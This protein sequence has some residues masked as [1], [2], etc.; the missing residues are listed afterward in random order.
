MVIVKPATLICWLRKAVRLFWRWKSPPRRR[1]IPLRLRQLIVQMVHDN[2]I[3][4]EE[5]IADELWPKLGIHVSPRTVRAY[6][7]AQNP[8]SG[9]RSPSWNAFV[10]NHASALVACNFLIAVTVH[11]RVVYVFVVMEITSTATS[12]MIDMRRSQANWTQPSIPLDC[13]R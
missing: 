10:R 7:P 2:P 13:G 9:R 8:S 12:F 6:W 3:W 5:R 4:G 1:R 11:F